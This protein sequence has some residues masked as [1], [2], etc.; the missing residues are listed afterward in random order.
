MAEASFYNIPDPTADQTPN[1]LKRSLEKISPKVSPP[2]KLIKTD[3]G[4][5]TEAQSP[6]TAMETIQTDTVDNS[7]VV[8]SIITALSSPEFIATFEK[9]IDK[10]VTKHFGPLASTMEDQAKEIVFLEKKW[11]N[12]T[13]DG[14]V[15]ARLQGGRV[16][17]IREPCDLLAGN[18]DGDQQ[19]QKGA[20]VTQ[21]DPQAGVT[22]Y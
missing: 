22:P 8:E 4:R 3:S 17:V 15:L 6:I 5:L 14:S 20:V 11:T 7:P 19:Q 10:C 2:D 13:K 9:I 21:T 18:K 12:W 16:I 1:K